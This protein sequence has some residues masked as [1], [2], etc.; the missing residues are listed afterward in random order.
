MT[1]QIKNTCVWFEMPVTDMERAKTFYSAVLEGEL[2]DEEGGPNPMAMFPMASEKSVGGHI[3]PGK[4]AAKG[5]G[6]TVHLAVNSTVEAAIERV[7][8]AGG[9][10]V[11][12]VIEI[13]KMRFAYCIDLDGNSF[14]VFQAQ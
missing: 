7:I 5:E 13:D 9:E 8:K 14:G 10:V 6:A 3:Y 1:N 2:V 4:P 11:S 12:P